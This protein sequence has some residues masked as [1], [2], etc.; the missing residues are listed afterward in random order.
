MY[1]MNKWAVFFFPINTAVHPDKLGFWRANQQSTQQKSLLVSL[2]HCFVT[3]EVKTSD[4]RGCNTPQPRN[5][6]HHRICSCWRPSCAAV[7]LWGVTVEPNHLKTVLCV[8]KAHHSIHS[9]NM[10]ETTAGVWRQMASAEEILLFA[11]V[12]AQIGLL[13]GTS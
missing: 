4:S 5:I 3:L 8:Y 12:E 13:W 10:T 6:L 7:E 11:V 1:R 2:L 9:E